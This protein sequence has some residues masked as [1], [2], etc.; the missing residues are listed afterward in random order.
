MGRVVGVL[1]VHVV[2][3]GTRTLR[4]LVNRRRSAASKNRNDVS[5][6]NHEPWEV[7]TPTQVPREAGV[8]PAM[9]RDFWT[10]SFPR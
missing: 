7:G 1:G 6:K 9:G 4:Q 10:R 3:G 8:R 2:N 5:C